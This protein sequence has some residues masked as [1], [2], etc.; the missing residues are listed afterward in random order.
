MQ[1]QTRSHPQK[2]T[3]AEA[4]P[5]GR[6]APQQPLV[7]GKWLLSALGIVV[8]LAAVCAY[9]TLCL[10]FYQ[11]SWQIIFHP[12]RTVIAHPNIPYQEIQFDYTETGK[13]QLTGWWIPAAP[14]AHH[15][16][17]TILYLH[18]GNGCLSDTVPR[19][20]SLHALDINVFAFDYRGFGKSADLHPSES[21]MNQDADAA[22]AYL[23]GTRHLPAHSIV[24]YGAGLGAPI[25]ASTA[26]RHPETAAL[27]LENISPTAS[28]LFAADAR[29][30]ILPVRLLTSDRFNAT[31]TL[32]TLPTQKLFLDLAGS[33][34]TQEAFNAARAPK[35]VFQIRPEDQARFRETMQRFLDEVLSH[36]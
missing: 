31:E 19:I 8:A 36:Q 14:D 15:S 29:T 32:K 7:S 4:R 1:K 21:S 22:L 12:S 24:L 5:A 2:R 9:A 17:N 34:Q 6:N 27:I 13:P 11:G 10:L 28:T 16:G 3:R 35:Q 33:P 25:A 23:T 30:K 26:A 20:E 18:D